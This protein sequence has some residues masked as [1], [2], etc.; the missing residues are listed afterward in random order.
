MPTHISADR[1]PGRSSVGFLRPRSAEPCPGFGGGTR[2]ILLSQGLE[3]DAGVARDD[4]ASEEKTWLVLPTNRECLFPLACRFF[5]EFKEACAKFRSCGAARGGGRCLLETAPRAKED[6]EP[7]VSAH[8]QK[9][10]RQSSAAACGTSSVCAGQC[11]SASGARQ[12]WRCASCLVCAHKS[13]PP[14]LDLRPLFQS[15]CDTV[16]RVCSDAA[17]SRN[18]RSAAACQWSRPL[19]WESAAQR[20]QRL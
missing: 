16:T 10:E 2:I 7:A 14:R 13:A 6:G 17:G 1:Q 8:R 19:R 9:I 11:G 4:K 20:G 3:Q 15:Y 5:K 12:L 18:T